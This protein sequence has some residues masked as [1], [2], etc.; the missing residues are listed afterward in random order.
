VHQIFSNYYESQGDSEK[1][2]TNYKA[3]VELTEEY[4]SEAHSARLKTVMFNRQLVLIQKEKELI[5]QKNK[6]LQKANIIIQEQSEALQKANSQLRNFAY[7]ASHD[8]KE[9]L[10]TMANFSMLLQRKVSDR[11]TSDELEFLEFITS[12]SKRMNKMVNDLLSYA[13]IEQQVE[14]DQELNLNEV[15]EVILS[16]LS[17]NISEVNASIKYEPLPSITS[18]RT[19]IKQLFQNLISNA[20][21]FKKE[22]QNPVVTIKYNVNG[23]FHR[24]TVKDNG[25][26]IKETDIDKIF[27]VFSRLNGI[28]DYAGSGIGLATCSKIVDELEG[29]ISVNSVFGEGSE[30]IVLLR[31]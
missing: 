1:A 20:I 2:L 11:L 26:G 8:L 24:F 16:D 14:R 28:A 17:L 4:K 3:Y 7:K 31:K 19:L 10:R 21:K 12:S 27:G 18:N 30:F 9:P 29:S 13:T 15:I 6:E 23:K 25:I 5:D 22:D